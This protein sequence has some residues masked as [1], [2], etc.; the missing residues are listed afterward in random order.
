MIKCTTILA[1]R[2]REKIISFTLNKDVMP[3]NTLAKL[4][5]QTCIALQS[6]HLVKG[7]LWNS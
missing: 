3:G 6:K 1:R 7:K 4:G 2:R 5:Q